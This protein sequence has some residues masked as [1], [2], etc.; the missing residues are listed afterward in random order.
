M[1]AITKMLRYVK[2]IKINYPPALQAMID[3]QSDTQLSN[4]FGFLPEFPNF[5]R[6]KLP[7]YTI[8]SKF[9]DDGFVSSFISTFETLY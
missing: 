6:A 8:P 3:N 4:L 9:A 1:S 2:Y 5:I 7:I